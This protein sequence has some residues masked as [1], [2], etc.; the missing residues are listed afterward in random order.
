MLVR[1]HTAVDA[2]DEV[3]KA[4]LSTSG[5]DRCSEL[6]LDVGYW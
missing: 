2:A 6:L 3:S 1:M 4:C 5:I